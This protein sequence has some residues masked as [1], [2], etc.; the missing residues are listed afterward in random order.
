MSLVTSH[1][2]F[3]DN[4]APSLT[5]H[6]EGLILGWPLHLLAEWA[7]AK[8]DGLEMLTLKVADRQVS[9]SGADLKF[10]AEA[11]ASGKGGIIYAHGERYLSTRSDKGKSPYV[12]SIK[13]D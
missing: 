6:A 7:H 3:D 12:I 8:G 5:V 1:I 4:N 10:I 2:S 11:L 9:V 13:V